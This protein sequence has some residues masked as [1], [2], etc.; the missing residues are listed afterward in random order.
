M[1]RL[2]LPSLVVVDQEWRKDAACR[3]NGAALFFAS[4]DGLSYSESAQQAHL[5][6]ERYCNKCPVANAC[7]EFA[8]VNNERYGIWGGLSE[9]ERA[10]VRRAQAK[11]KKSSK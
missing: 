7:L 10:K 9:R 2:D 8:I 5:A 1:S 11:V 3:G 4:H 6:K